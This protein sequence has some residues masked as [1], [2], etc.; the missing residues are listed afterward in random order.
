[1]QFAAEH[2]WLGSPA[3]TSRCDLLLIAEV[4]D[5]LCRPATWEEKSRSKPFLEF[6]E[7]AA[8]FF[9]QVVKQ[10]SRV[11]WIDPN[12]IPLFLWGN[13]LQRS[14]ASVKIGEFG[15]KS[16]QHPLSSYFS[17]HWAQ[18][19]PFSLLGQTFGGDSGYKSWVS[20]GLFQ[21][22]VIPMLSFQWCLANSWKLPHY[23]AP[24]AIPWKGYF[25]LFH[26]YFGW[27]DL[28]MGLSESRWNKWDTRSLTLIN[29]WLGMCC[30]NTECLLGKTNKN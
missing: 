21:C 22:F 7:H 26:Q 20:S 15:K 23:P 27:L 9:T 5:S 28:Y 16:R 6:Q 18:M 8:S 25:L 19:H 24:A 12:R 14:S 11:F 10:I 30:S 2:K 1:M 29:L 13:Y 3:V 17:Q 4:Y